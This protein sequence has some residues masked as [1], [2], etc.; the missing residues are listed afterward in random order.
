MAL[1]Y[2]YPLFLAHV[3]LFL[4]GKISLLEAAITLKISP[5]VDYA[6]D[7][8]GDANNNGRGCFKAAICGF[9]SSSA[10][11]SK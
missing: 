2:I 5:A 8:Y 4:R 6:D 11:C 9:K 10:A 7:D 3:A 1:K